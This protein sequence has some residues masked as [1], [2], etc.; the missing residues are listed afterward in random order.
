MNTVRVKVVI[1]GTRDEFLACIMLRAASGLSW[2]RA[3]DTTADGCACVYVS[4]QGRGGV[5][6]VHRTYVV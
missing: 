3:A 4:V 2:P 6:I 5:C 1:V